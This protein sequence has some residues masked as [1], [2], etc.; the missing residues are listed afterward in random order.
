MKFIIALFVASLASSSPAGFP[1]VLPCSSISG[2]PCRCPFG[3]DYAESVTTAIIG[4][5]ARD[6]EDLTNDFF[7]PAWAGLV[8]RSVQGPNNFPGLSIR[9]LNITTSVG[10]YIVSERLIFRFVWPDGSFEQRSEQRGIVPYLSGNGSFS[11]HW[12]TLKS[13]RIF[14]NQT[15]IRF[16]IYACQTG[17]PINFSAAHQLALSNV[18]G[19]LA[20]AGL[21]PGISTDPVSAQL[22]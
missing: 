8:V 3:T 7:D 1:F 13:D 10:N 12:L 2:T 9:D 6:V 14:E 21:L 22:F 5:K 18:T 16:S 19:I 11:G 17:H 20:T 4:A 15:L